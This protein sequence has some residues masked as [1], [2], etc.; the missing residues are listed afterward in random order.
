MDGAPLAAWFVDRSAGGAGQVC[1]ATG[2]DLLRD[3]QEALQARLSDAPLPTFDGSS[4]GPEAVPVNDPT[5]PARGWDGDLLRALWAVASADRAP[6]GYLAAVRDDAARGAGPVSAA[7]AALGVWEAELSSGVARGTGAPVYGVGSPDAVGIPTDAV[8]PA[9][10]AP[11]APPSTGATRSGL[12]CN[13]TPAA[14]TALAPAPTPGPSGA[15]VALA[16]LVVGAVVAGAL[17]V[18]TVPLTQR[19]A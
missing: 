2:W 17:F 11:P 7:T 18:R 12:A 19:R 16:L 1:A 9:M 6:A 10:D 13:A 3:L 14:P 8:L 15:A 5:L 4:V